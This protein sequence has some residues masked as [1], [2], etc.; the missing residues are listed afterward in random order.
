MKVL[1]TGATGLIGQELGRKLVEKGHKVFIISRDSEKAKKQVSFPCEVIVGDLVKAPIENKFLPQMEGVIHLLGENIS[2]GRWTADRKKKIMESRSIGTRNLLRSLGGSVSLKS[3]IS[4]SAVG[5]YG[6]RGE[7]LL[8]EE[9]AAGA[10]FLSDV[11]KEWEAPFTENWNPNKFPQCRWNVFRFGVVLSGKG[12]ALKKMAVPFK[13]GL[14]GRLGDG[15]QWVSWI[16]IQDLVELLCL[17]L[18][19]KNFQGV[20]NAVSP[21]AVTNEQLT[22]DLAMVLVTK[23]AFPV[24]AIALKIALGEMSTVLLASQKASAEKVQKA[25]FNFRF[26]DLPSALRESFNEKT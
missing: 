18:E 13:F 3:L 16:Q 25:G 2:S 17:A 12:G 8:S 1:I 21:Q 9:S 15:K 22:K 7:E 26:A 20:Y 14:G 10:G 24:P 6:D 11:C 23:E 5:Y 19:N 4:A